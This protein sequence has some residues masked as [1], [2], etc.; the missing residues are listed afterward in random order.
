M[1]FLI[2]VQGGREEEAVGWT[3]LSKGA[4]DIEDFTVARAD[5]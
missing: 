5:R 2:V 1:A 4:W 3:L